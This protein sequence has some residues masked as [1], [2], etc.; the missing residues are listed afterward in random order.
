[1]FGIIGNIN[2]TTIGKKHR[3]ED[4]SFSAC[5]GQI[6]YLISWLGSLVTLTCC[7]GSKH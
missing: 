3:E 5:L 6:P 1:M 7:K 2:E 4:K